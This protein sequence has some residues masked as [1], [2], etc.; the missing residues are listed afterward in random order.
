MNTIGTFLANYVHLYLSYVRIYIL[1]M[2]SSSA[3]A[4]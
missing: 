2:I 1:E 3:F 4:S